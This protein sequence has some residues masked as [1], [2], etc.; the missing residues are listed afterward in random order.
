M[1]AKLWWRAKLWLVSLQYRLSIYCGYIWYDNAPSTRNTGMKIMSDLHS[2]TTHHS[3]PLRASYGVSF[4]N[5]AKKR[6]RDIS[7]VHCNKH[8]SND[9]CCTI[10]IMSPWSLCKLDC[11]SCVYVCSKDV[12]LPVQLQRAMAAEAEAAR[13]ARAKVGKIR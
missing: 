4:V 6:D 2:R 13:E 12:R 11:W 10:P 3:S 5:Y 1:A 9:N 8:Y 7:R